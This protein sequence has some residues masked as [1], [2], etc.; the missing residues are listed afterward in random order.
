[1][2]FD[3]ILNKINQSY[4]SLLI[5]VVAL[6]SIG[7]FIGNMT[8]PG[9]D[10]WYTTLQR[11][12]LTPANY[13]FGIVWTIL[14]I[15]L[16]MSGWAIWSSQHSKL[17]LIKIVYILQL[18]LNWTWAPLFFIYHQPGLALLCIGLI[19]ALTLVVIFKTY[20]TIPLASYLLM[21]YFVWVSFASYLNF[22]IWLY[23]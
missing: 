14:Y 12:P 5:W 9:V 1:M 4:V 15:M 6:V 11:S 23:N 16:A 19:I 8:R 10:A 7:A 22:Y 2:S 3:K 18:M 21:P 17:G 20:H 13:V